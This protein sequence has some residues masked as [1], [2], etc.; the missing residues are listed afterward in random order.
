MP[1]Y[2]Y[3]VYMRVYW[4]KDT[5]ESYEQAR[6]KAM[7]YRKHYQDQDPSNEYHFEVEQILGED[8]E[9]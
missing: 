9:V 5:F 4:D 1:K 2:E 8:D 7:E 6:D 3:G